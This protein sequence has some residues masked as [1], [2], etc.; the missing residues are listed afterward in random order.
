MNLKKYASAPIIVLLVLGSNIYSVATVTKTITELKDSNLQNIKK[1]EL[2]TIKAIIDENAEK[3]KMQAENVK[4]SSEREILSKYTNNNVLTEDLSSVGDKPVFHVLQDN[5]TGK[6]LNVDNDN[7]DMFVWIPKLGKV[8]DTSK[9]CAFEKGE[10]VTKEG[11]IEKQYNKVLANTAILSFINQENKKYTFWQYLPSPE[12]YYTPETMDESEIDKLYNLYGYK[13]LQYLEFLCPAYLR[14]DEDIVG[15]PD[16]N[17]NGIKT[18]N[19]KIIFIQGFNIV[20]DLEK[21]HADIIQYY[22]DLFAH[23]E[24]KYNAI[25]NIIGSVGILIT[26]ILLLSF[27]SIARK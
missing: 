18:D 19:N 7:N 9:N 20:D 3:G 22:E 14:Q 4:N 6:H 27:I 11:E 26:V 13:G 12:G 10:S 21:N 23:T 15:V 25:N 2:T 16:V 24:N 1:D 5:I 8:A 17:Q